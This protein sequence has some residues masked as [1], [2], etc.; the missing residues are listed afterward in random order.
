MASYLDSAEQLA[1]HRLTNAARAEGLEKLELLARAET[2]QDDNDGLRLQAIYKCCV[3]AVITL[4]HPARSKVLTI[5][6]SAG[7]FWTWANRLVG[8]DAV[9][10]G[11]EGGRVQARAY[12]A[13]ARGRWLAWTDEAG[14]PRDRPT[15]CR[16]TPHEP[17][18]EDY[19]TWDWDLLG[20]NPNAVGNAE[21]IAFLRGKQKKWE[22]EQMGM[23]VRWD[24][25]LDKCLDAAREAFG[26]EFE[27]GFGLFNESRYLWG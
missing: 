2:L 9:W 23:Q 16:R 8:D 1:R 17:V 14:R 7:E 25:Y 6:Q 21:T 19:W 3:L 5:E 20:Q 10:R 27:M 18:M 26:L 22:E 15:I 12:L 13:Y 24:R 4:H 11:N